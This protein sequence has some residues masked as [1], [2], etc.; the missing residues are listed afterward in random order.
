MSIWGVEGL[1]S[2]GWFQPIA[3][4]GLSGGHMDL[5]ETQTKAVGAG[6]PRQ[7]LEDERRRQLITAAAELFL[8]KGYHATTMDDVARCA[9]MSKKTVYQVFS[10]KS[11][12]LDALLS[13]WLAPVTIP[14][15]SDGRPPR[16]VLTEVLS[17]IINFALAERQVL[18]TRLLIAETPYSEE[19]AA[20]LDRQGCGRGMGALEQW[21]ASQAALGSLK[22]DD[23]DEVSNMLFFTAAGDVL[24][25]LLLRTRAQPT[26]EEVNARVERTVA[27]FFHAQQFI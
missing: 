10:A 22:I 4:D 25:G 11:E 14:V 17:R 5:M 1:S 26:V 15:E 9:G 23:P 6:R 20:A 27:N 3:S 7:M 8:H 18:M 2:Y 19:I 16:E 13:D 21:L 12:L 24:M